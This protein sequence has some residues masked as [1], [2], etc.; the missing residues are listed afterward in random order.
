MTSLAKVVCYWS[1]LFTLDCR[2]VPC[3]ATLQPAACLSHVHYV[4]GGAA[5]EINHRGRFA[6][7]V[8]PYVVFSAAE[9]NEF[10]IQNDRAGFAAGDVA[11]VRAGLQPRGERGFGWSGWY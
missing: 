5:D 9:L 8:T 7:E 6:R 10:S 4:T 2:A 3:H 1:V 11:G